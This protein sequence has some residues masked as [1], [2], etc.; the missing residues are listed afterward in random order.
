LWLRCRGSTCAVCVCLPHRS[1]GR[2]FSGC[3]LATGLRAE[4]WAFRSVG[5]QYARARRT[6]ALVNYCLR[7]I[8]SELFLVA[9]RHAI[10]WGVTHRACAGGA[11]STACARVMVLV[12]ASSGYVA[13]TG[14]FVFAVGAPAV[15]LDSA[16]AIAILCTSAAVIAR[17]VVSVGVTMFV[18]AV[19]RG[20]AI[21][22]GA[23]AAFVVTY[24]FA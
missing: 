14:V 18:A 2:W 1:G 10:F 7:H 5:R 15:T 8:L 13:A 11:S 22:V 24:W 19:S 17:V 6:S 23:A 21:S 12:F 4:T 20:P 3:P 9:P 16:C